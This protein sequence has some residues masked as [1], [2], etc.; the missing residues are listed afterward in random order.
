MHLLPPPFSLLLILL[1]G[2]IVWGILRVRGPDDGS[3]L[4]GTGDELLWGL[5]LLAGMAVIVFMGFLFLGARF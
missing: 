3:E 5:L 1:L 2:L 4:G